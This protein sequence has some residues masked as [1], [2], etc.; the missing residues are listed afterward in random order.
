[1]SSSPRS[2]VALVAVICA[3]CADDPPQRNPGTDAANDGRVM[4]PS[5]AMT[6]P[7]D[8][9][10]DD[11]AAEPPPPPFDGGPDDAAPPSPPPSDAGGDAGPGDAGS[12]PTDGGPV[13]V[14]CMTSDRAGTCLDVADCTGDRMPVPG[15]CPGPREI[16]CCV[17]R[18][19]TAACDPAVMP[20][21]NVGLV[22][23]AGEGGCPAGMLVV[24]ASPAFCVDRF[25]SALEVVADDGTV[26]SWSPFHNPGTRRIRAVSLRGAVPQGYI[27]GRQAEAA[28]AEAGKRLCTDAEWLRACQGA[29]GFT[30]PYGNE[31]MPGVCN[32]A[33]D[34]HPAVERFGTSADW[35]WSMLGDACISQ[36]PDSLDRT[37][38]NAGCE[39]SD[40]ALDMM[41]NLHEWTADPAGTF[42]GGFY[43]DTYR[44]GPGCLYR[45][46]AHDVGHWDYSTGFRCCADP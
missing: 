31:R 45:T 25:E 28:C 10:R 12:P 27:T 30:Y 41:G 42:R 18:E 33:R 9:S 19:A 36:L 14:P 44:N 3:S 46:T 26:T 15:F 11:D 32:D 6:S 35:I 21:P 22:E 38:A 24:P 4:L 13:G 23:E 7:L 2:L 40:G 20:A 8:G 5:D 43:V 16:Q 29:D 39:S 1:M 37:G 34:V 17:A